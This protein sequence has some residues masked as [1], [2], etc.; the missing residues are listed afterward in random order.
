VEPFRQVPVRLRFEHRSHRVALWGFTP[1]ATL[2]RLIDRRL[3]VVAPSEDGLILTT[4]L[5]QLLGVKAGQLLTVEVM[6]GARRIKQMAVTGMVDEVV[7]LGAYTRLS[8][9]NR[10]LE[11]EQSITGAYLKVDAAA[12]AILYAQL[13][14]TPAVAAVTLRQAFW[15]SL[16][17]ILEESV[18]VASSINIVFACVIAFGVV[19]NSARIALSE[20]GNELASLRVLGFSR[21]EVTSILLGEQG[22]LTLVAVP[23]G[24]LLGYAVCALLSYRLDTELYRMPLV[25]SRYTF[26]FAFVVVAVA[27]AA[28]GLLVARRISKLDLIAVLKTRE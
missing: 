7:G 14:R 8:T 10:L 12:N 27:A 15:D 22:L 4:K 11:E 23:V 5:A 20:R 24:F 28:S 16:N 18:M 1:D 13:K 17:K 6:E 9:L 21:A 26:G 19:F 2:R 3:N 25:L